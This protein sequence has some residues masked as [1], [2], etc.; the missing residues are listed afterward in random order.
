MLSCQVLFGGPGKFVFCVLQLW[1]L[2]CDV[3]GW[4]LPQCSEMPVMKSLSW[5]VTAGSSAHS[6]RPHTC[7]GGSKLLASAAPF[8]AIFRLKSPCRKGIV[9]GLTSDPACWICKLLPCSLPSLPSACLH[10]CR[11]IRG[12]LRIVHW[13]MELAWRHCTEN[14]RLSTVQFSLSSRTWTTR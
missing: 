4:Q 6:T 13:S 3:K 11:D 9:C 10:E 1:S 14:R 7:G 5:D 12:G 2:S 8:S